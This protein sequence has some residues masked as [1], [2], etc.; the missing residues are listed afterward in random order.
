MKKIPVLVVLLLLCLFFFWCN[1]KDKDNWE[2][3]ITNA[4]E[5][6]CVEKWWNVETVSEWWEDFVLCVF[7]DGS[8]CFV[9]DLES[10]VCEKWDI[11]YYD[12]ENL[13]ADIETWV[14]LEYEKV[15]CSSLPEN[16]VC[17]KDGNTYNNSCYLEDAWVEEETELAEVVDWECVFG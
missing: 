16:I 3:I 11:Q 10:G 8:F 5:S 7:E 17:G 12:A 2:A 14:T 4:D 6:L 9:E 15:D 1:K 13:E